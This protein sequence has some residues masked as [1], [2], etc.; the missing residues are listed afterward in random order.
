MS[1]EQRVW[2]ITGSNRGIGLELTKQLLK[3]PSNV[4]IAGC[5][6]PSKATA[7]NTLAES[8]KGRVHI[9]Q[10]DLADRQSVKD[11]VPKV[12]AA[13]GDKGIDYL[14]NNAAI[15]EGDDTALSLDPDVLERTFHVNVA[16]TAA[17]SQAFLPLLEKGAKKTIVNISSSVGSI[18]YDFGPSFASYSISK[19]ALNMLTYKQ[20]KERPEFTVISMCPGHLKTDMGG[21]YASTEVSDG[22]AGVLKIVHALKPEDSGKFFS[23]EG[24]LR[25]W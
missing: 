20:A 2:L 11:S 15:N 9:V 21:P 13:L 16:G 23:H 8:N 6:N 22:V 18:G 17:V 5:R 12:A 7:L 1:N 14:I 4:V 10:L 3:S 25:P 24:V 19:T